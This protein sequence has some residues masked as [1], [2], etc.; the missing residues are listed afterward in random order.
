MQY[1]F[2]Q[3]HRRDNTLSLKWNPNFYKGEFHGRTDLLPLWVADMDY[4]V[5]EGILKRFR[6]VLEG[7]IFGYAGFDDEYF[8]AVAHWNKKRHGVEI[9][10]ET[11]LFTP[12]IVPALDYAVQTFVKEGEAV[13]IQRPV[14]YPFTKAIENNGRKLVNSPLLE[15]PGGNYSMDC[16]DFEQKIVEN[17]VKLFILCNPHNPV[18]QVWTRDEL[19]KIAAIC[20]KHKVIMLS[21]EIH[22]DLMFFGSKFTSVLTLSDEV[23]N[24]SIVCNAVSKTFNLAGLQ[25]SNTIIHNSDLRARFQK[26]LDCSHVAL[27]NAFAV[28]GVKGCY[29]ESDDWYEQMIKYIEGNIAFASEYIAANIKPLS[30]RKHQGTYLGWIDVRGLKLS[31]EQ[32]V[33]LCEVRAKVAFDYGYWFGP[34]GEGFL[35]IN[36]ACTRATLEQALKKLEAAVKSL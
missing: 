9:K 23:K 18:G 14:Y 6:K 3:V 7:K 34:D 17:K 27:P 8:E 30:M 15:G 20:L 10:R 21:D 19:E 22:Y 33:D 5:S 35:R 1:N 29:F 24:N 32:L 11:V 31:N 25:V 12:G 2:D 36:L 16:A 4:A 26:T 28:E 13:I